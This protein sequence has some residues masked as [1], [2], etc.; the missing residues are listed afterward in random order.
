V[1]SARLSMLPSSPTA[2]ATNAINGLGIELLPRFHQPGANV[3]LSPYSIQSALAMAYAGADGDTR[4]EMAKV[5]HYPKDE[6]EVHGSFAA[7]RKELDDVVQESTGRCAEGR[8]HGETTD[9]VT[10]IVANR[11]YGQ[12]GYEFRKSFLTLLQET[13]DAP[14]E[15]MDFVRS[16]SA[17]ARR[18]N[19]WVEEQ[20]RQ[21]IRDLIQDG[22]LDTLTRLLLVNAI[23]LKAPWL[24]EFQEFATQPRERRDHDRHSAYRLCETR[25]VHRSR[26]SLQR[27]RHSVPCLAASQNGWAC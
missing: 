1:A 13:Y 2:I 24:K 23:Y 18:I 7:L 16:S 11:L 3:L 4:A 15:P 20:T 10:L 21:R 19:L 26:N 14:F 5:L 12:A 9:P 6:D 25:R 22:A 8:K 17:A 27:W